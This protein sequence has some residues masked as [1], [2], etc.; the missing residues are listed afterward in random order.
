VIAAYEP[1]SAKYSPVFSLHFTTSSDK[2]QKEQIRCNK[3]ESYSFSAASAGIPPFKTPYYNNDCGCRHDV[4]RAHG[5]R[6]LAS[7][8]LNEQGWN[9]DV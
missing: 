1:S 4:M 9:R 7:T 8:N 5:F 2:M 3:W 6:A